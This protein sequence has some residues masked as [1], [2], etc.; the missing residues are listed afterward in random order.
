MV[1]FYC[2]DLLKFDKEAWKNFSDRVGWRVNQ[3]WID[4][5]KVTFDTIAPEGYF[6][7][8]WYVTNNFMEEPLEGWKWL[9]RSAVAATRQPLRSA[10]VGNTN[11]LGFTTGQRT[12]LLCQVFTA[13]SCKS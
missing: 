4:Y 6:P 12:I 2:A 5:E 10:F 3:T 8:Y 9:F 7:Y 11:P 1:W 13:K